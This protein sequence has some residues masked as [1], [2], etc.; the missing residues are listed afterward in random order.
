M[1]VP[2]RRDARGRLL[3]GASLNP[4]GRSSDLSAVR[5]ELRE[6]SPTAARALV[7]LV[8][9]PDPGTGLRAIEISPAPPRGNWM[10]HGRTEA[11]TDDN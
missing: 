7:A 2:V 8:D 3:P 1:T 10:F 4:G 11:V 6:H 9:H 5:A